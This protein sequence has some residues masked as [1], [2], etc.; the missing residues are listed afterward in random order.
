MVI[1]STLLEFHLGIGFSS[2]LIEKVR[3]EYGL[4]YLIDVERQVL[5]GGLAYFQIIISSVDVDKVELVKQ[6]VENVLDRLRHGDL[7]EDYL[8]KRYQFLRYVL[9]SNIRRVLSIADS[10]A[11][12][13]LKGIRKSVDEYN[14][15]VESR[16]REIPIELIRSGTWSYILPEQ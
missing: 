10:E 7:S 9:R 13:V 11:Y 8:H 4:S 12:L 14:R 6:L 2:M 15:D 16:F 5:D 1:K 3:K